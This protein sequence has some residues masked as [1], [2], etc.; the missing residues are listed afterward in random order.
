MKLAIKSQLYE[1]TFV[2]EE[3]PSRMDSNRH[4]DWPLE[5]KVGLGLRL[6][7]GLG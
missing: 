2:S 4:G 5:C 6:G 1:S 3:L 7:L